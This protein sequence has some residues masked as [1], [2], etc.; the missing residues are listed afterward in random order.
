MRPLP[1]HPVKL[2]LHPALALALVLCL[3][4]VSLLRGQATEATGT[5]APGAWLLE[6]DLL[7]FSATGA[8]EGAP[9]QEG[10]A[11][12]SF[13]LSTGLTQHL[14]LQVGFETWLQEK[15]K[16]EP[17]ETVSGQGR[18]SVRVKGCLWGKDGETLTLALLPYLQL[19]TEARGLGSRKA[20]YGLVV[21]LSLPLGATDSLASMVG[22]HSAPGEEGRVTTYFGGLVWTQRLT[23]QADL[24][25][26]ALTEHET[27]G[28]PGALQVGAGL[29]LT[30]S[31]SL[32]WDLVCYFGV[33]RRAPDW[34]PV[35]RLTYGF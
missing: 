19:P 21:P 35:L 32:Q 31:A 33:N 27:R 17:P 2:R 16:G 30:P 23:E 20:E 1:T 24:Y 15:S 29:L 8:R 3:G 10:L 25:F 14:D 9:A 7:G 26:E 28:L 22:V 6:A 18:T 34:N 11:V 12:G 4:P 5:V 13:L